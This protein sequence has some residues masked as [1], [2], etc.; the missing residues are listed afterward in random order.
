[1]YCPRCWAMFDYGYPAFPVLSSLGFVL[2][3]TPF[4][5]HMQAW[6]SGT[7]IYMAWVAIGCLNLFIN[8]IIWRDSAINFSPVWCDICE[9]LAICVSA[10]LDTVMFD[11][12]TLDR[13]HLGCY[14]RCITLHQPPPVS[15]CDG[16]DRHCLQTSCMLSPTNASVTMCFSTSVSGA[17]Y[18]FCRLRY[19]N[20][21]P[22]SANGPA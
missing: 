17:P 18:H 22:D 10:T 9:L 7:C 13:G 14:T 1:M 2:V 21:N 4:P 6:N 19:R 8:S 5:W 3:L 16:S 12:F 11:S 20:R 15:Y